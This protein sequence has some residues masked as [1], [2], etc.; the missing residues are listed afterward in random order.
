M[1]IVSPTSFERLEDLI[2][3]A[4]GVRKTIEEFESVGKADAPPVGVPAPTQLEDPRR[5]GADTDTLIVFAVGALAVLGVM[6]VLR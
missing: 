2:K 3:G 5:R 6:A 4:T 1:A